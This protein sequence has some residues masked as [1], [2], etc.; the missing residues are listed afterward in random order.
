[1]RGLRPLRRRVALRE[2]L[3]QLLEQLAVAGRDAVERRLLDAAPRLLVGRAALAADAELAQVE[4][5]IRVPDLAE[6]VEQLARSQALGLR[7]G[8]VVGEALG[9]DAELFD[10]LVER[11]CPRRGSLP[12][13]E[14]ELAAG[15][16]ERLVDA[17]QHPPEA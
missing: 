5:A 10:A 7:R 13:L 14:H 16:A 11:G 2:A 9:G 8:G 15:G 3:Q 4:Q 6:E 12:E 17:D 1:D